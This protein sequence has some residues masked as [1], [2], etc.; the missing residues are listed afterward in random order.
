MDFIFGCGEAI[1]ENCEI[2]SLTDARD[3]GYAAAPAHS[4]S[5]TEGFRFLNC[6]FTAEKGVS[7]RLYL[8]CPPVAGLWTVP[9]PELRLRGAYLS[10][11]L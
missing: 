3:I 1:F 5:Q 11:G 8:P 2:R 9:V 7:P 6:R 4:R 10:P